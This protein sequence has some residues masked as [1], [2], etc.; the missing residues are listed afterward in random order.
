[1]ALNQDA[2]HQCSGW[3]I[4]LVRRSALQAQNC[5]WPLFALDD[6]ADASPV[7][8][9]SD[10]AWMRREMLELPGVCHS[11]R[12]YIPRGGCSHGTGHPNFIRARDEVTACGSSKSLTFR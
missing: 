3:Y 11:R 5:G 4:E 8:H 7:M 10:S 1:M 12:G 2:R 6:D 9:W